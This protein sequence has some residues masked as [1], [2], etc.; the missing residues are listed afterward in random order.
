MQID[1]LCYRYRCSCI[2]T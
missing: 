2:V 1:L